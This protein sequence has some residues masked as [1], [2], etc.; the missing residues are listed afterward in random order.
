[1]NVCKIVQIPAEVQTSIILVWDK[2]ACT[3]LVLQL[4]D[5]PPAVIT[6][7]LYRRYMSRC[8]SR[9]G[10]ARCGNHNYQENYRLLFFGAEISLTYKY[11]NKGYLSISLDFKHKT[12]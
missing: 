9:E 3:F 6:K 7:N 8:I 1:M 2:N 12:M 5:L 11:C 10:K 4:R